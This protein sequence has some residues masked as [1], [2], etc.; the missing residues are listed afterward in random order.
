M[1][2]AALMLLLLNGMN[3][4][5]IFPMDGGHVLQDTIFC[6]NRW[7]EAVF[8]LLA[9]GGL[10]LLGLAGKAFLYLGIA[11]AVSLPITFKLAKIK[12]D[13]NKLDLPQPAPGE[14]RIPMPTAQ[15]IITAVKAAFASKMRPSNKS[16]AQHSLN[17]FESLNAKPPGVLAT[18]GLLAMQGG[19]LFIAVVMGLILAF[20]GQGEL[21]DFA[22]A[23]T[24]QPQHS[25]ACN[26][27]QQWGT[28]PEEAHPNHPIVTTFKK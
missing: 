12:E 24:R 23:A 26:A 15:A 18:L 11:L 14:D 6:R 27:L 9:I 22:Q 10:L 7:L 5:P 25:V 8:R 4:L 21:K 17:V 2:K 19:G 13:L 1:K 20:T 16:L 3:L 28:A